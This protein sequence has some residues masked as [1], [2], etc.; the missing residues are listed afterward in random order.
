LIVGKGQIPHVRD[1]SMS[2]VGTDFRIRKRLQTG[3]LFAESD[4]I[5]TQAP[6]GRV[7]CLGWAGIESHAHLN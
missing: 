6:S 3:L 7:L 5:E 2:R 1:A 4:T